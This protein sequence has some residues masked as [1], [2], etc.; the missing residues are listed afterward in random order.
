MQSTMLKLF[1]F[2]QKQKHEFF[3]LASNLFNANIIFSIDIRYVAYDSILL[4]TDS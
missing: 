3:I 4:S 1:K 2:P